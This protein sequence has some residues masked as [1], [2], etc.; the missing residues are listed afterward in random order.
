MSPSEISATFPSWGKDRVWVHPACST[1]LLPAVSTAVAAAGAAADTAATTSTWALARARVSLSASLQGATRPMVRMG[2][3]ARWSTMSCGSVMGAASP[4]HSASTAQQIRPRP[5][6]QYHGFIA[7]PP[8][9]A[10]VAVPS[11]FGGLLVGSSWRCP[12]RSVASSSGLRGSALLVRWIGLRVRVRSGYPAL[13]LNYPVPGPDPSQESAPSH[14]SVRDMTQLYLLP[15]F[16]SVPMPLYRA[17]SMARLCLELP[18]C[19]L[20]GTHHGLPRC[21]MACLCIEHVTWHE[22]SYMT[23]S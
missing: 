19:F 6:R 18:T 16:S 15:D 11:S 14:V 21:T 7:G 3:I 23:L 2:S 1:P 8:H 12:P 5:N 9:R 17:W 4:L 10:F 13:A 20:W 22:G